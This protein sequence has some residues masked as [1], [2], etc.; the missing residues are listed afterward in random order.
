MILLHLT[1]KMTINCNFFQIDGFI[2]KYLSC[3]SK[4]YNFIFVLMFYGCINRKSQLMK[5][6]VHFVQRAWMNYSL[7]NTNQYT[8]LNADR[9][10]R[11]MQ[12]DLYDL[13]P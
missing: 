2:F 1:Y 5:I 11:S 10:S 7:E 8:V 3:I 13:Q 4:N 6:T 9:Q 12:I